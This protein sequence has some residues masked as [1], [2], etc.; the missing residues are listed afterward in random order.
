MLLSLNDYI[1][2]EFWSI[3]KT[4]VFWVHRESLA[5]KEI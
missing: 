4:F 5:L 2:K 1:R 3:F